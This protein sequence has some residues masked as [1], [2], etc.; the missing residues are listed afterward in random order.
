MEVKA[1]VNTQ[2]ALQMNSQNKEAERLNSTVNQSTE[3]QEKQIKE[4]EKEQIEKNKKVS[5]KYEDLPKDVIKEATENLQK[6]LSMLNSQLKIETDKETGIQ[7]VKIVDKDTKEV[8]KQL[9]P[10]AVLKI[11]KYI[12]EITGLLFEKKD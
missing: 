8:I 4:I 5:L 2:S 12:D 11:A 1:V 9:P 6:K 3:L 10:E 7:V